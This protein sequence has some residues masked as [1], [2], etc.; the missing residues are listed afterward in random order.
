[1]TSFFAVSGNSRRSFAFVFSEPDCFIFALLPKIEFYTSYMKSFMRFTAVLACAAAL[2]S[3]KNKFEVAAPYKNITVVYGLLDMVDTAHY[4]RI[5]KAFMDN[6]KSAFDMAKE[7]DSSFYKNLTVTMKEL[8]ESG[9]LIASYPMDL[10][11]LTAEGYAKDSG[12]FFDTPNLAYKFKAALNPAHSYRLVVYNGT[13]GVTD[14]AETPVLDADPAVFGLVEWKVPTQVITFSR[15]FT[16]DGKNLFEKNYQ[17]TLPKNAAMS[18][19]YLR[20]HWID[21][22]L[23]TGTSVRRSADFSGFYQDAG[24]PSII[25]VRNRDI[26]AF[27]NETLGA[28]ASANQ[29]RYFDSCDMILYIAGNEYKRYQELNTNMGGLTSSEVK[30]QYTNIKGENVLGL[31]STRTRASRFQI[32]ISKDTRDSIALNPRTANLNIRFL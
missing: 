13:T 26:Y 31:F 17:A 8:S 16:F 27:L 20:F 4:V 12:T 6:N 11:D 1:M 32:P 25:K 9:A 30:P 2:V 15:E 29:Y 7:P 28:P 21:S 14:S 24:N 22:N 5:Q 10:V 18:Q 3:C 23:S 19:L